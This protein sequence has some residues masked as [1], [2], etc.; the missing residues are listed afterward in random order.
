M[1]RYTAKNYNGQLTG[2]QGIYGFWESRVPELLSD[3]FDLLARPTILINLKLPFG[4][5]LKIP[6][7]RL[8]LCCLWSGN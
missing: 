4:K 1:F 8:T 7:S 2:Q 5:S 3:E 6:I